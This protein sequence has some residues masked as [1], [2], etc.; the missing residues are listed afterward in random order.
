M[1]HLSAGTAAA[2]KLKPLKADMLP[3]TAYLLHGKRCRAACSF[4]PRGQPGSSEKHTRLGRVTWPLF[5]R[6]LLEKPLGLAEQFGL[7][8]ICLQSVALNDLQQ[9]LMPV[10]RWI[11]KLSSLPLSVSVPVEKINQVE[12]LY[13]AGAD[14]VTIALDVANHLL[15]REYKSGTLQERLDL[16]LASAARWPGRMSTHLI[17]GLGETEEELLKL[18][19]ML[20]EKNI[21]VGLFAFTP[22]PGTPLQTRQAPA[23]RHYR[24]IQ[25][26]LFLLRQEPDL[27][28]QLQFRQGHLIDL[29][30]SALQLRKYLEAGEAFRTSGC[31]GCNRPYYNERPGKTAYNYP[32]RLE[33]AEVDRILDLLLKS[34]EVERI[35]S[36][37]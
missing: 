35:T 13:S 27:L 24:R 18:G 6:D 11:K 3:T 12:L 10:I 14:R 36:E 8:R 37:A 33:A 26:A 20:M 1:I 2:L 15:Y 28:S 32:L 5:P 9:E 34:L 25:A 29:G 21:T 17:C 19:A 31:A 23:E 4:C 30:I 16:L 7:Q 22:L